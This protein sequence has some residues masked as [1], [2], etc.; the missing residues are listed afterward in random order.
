MNLRYK[1]MIDLQVRM[2]NSS[3]ITGKRTGKH[4]L[5]SNASWKSGVAAFWSYCQKHKEILWL[6]FEV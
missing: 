3:C 2:R 1:H 4:A 6:E 5:E